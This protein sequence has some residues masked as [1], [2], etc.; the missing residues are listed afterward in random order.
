[1]MIGMATIM[2]TLKKGCQTPRGRRRDTAVS[3]N[4]HAV[5]QDL[6]RAGA[7]SVGRAA[8]RIMN[9]LHSL[10]PIENVDFVY[11]LSTFIFEPVRWNARFGW[12]PLSEHEK[13]ASST[14]G[15]RSGG[16]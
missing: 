13:Q 8:M 16:A 12:R 15:K 7:P 11:T 6:I 14:T 10:Y 5:E 1:M 3:G 4:E 2:I 9:R